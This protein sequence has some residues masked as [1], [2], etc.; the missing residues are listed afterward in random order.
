MHGALDVVVTDVV[1]EPL[2]CA[3]E[4]GA[5]KTINISTQARELEKYSAGKGSFDVV[6]E[7]SGNEQALISALEVIRPQGRLVQLGLGGMVTIPQNLIVAKEIELCGT[8]RFHEE[9]AWAVALIGAGRLPL[10]PLLTDVY[11]V[12]DVGNAFETANNRTTSMKVQLTFN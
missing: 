8:F 4:V 5:D 9:F 1:D 11:P 7:A 2:K 12:A 6:I 3:A 10:K